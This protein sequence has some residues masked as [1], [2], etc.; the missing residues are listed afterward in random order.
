MSHYVSTYRFFLVCGVGSSR[1]VRI[2]H[3]L[4]R[5]DDGDTELI[6]QTLKGTQEPSQVILT[7]G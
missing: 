1:R 2:R 6:R 7:G 3:N 4:I 5:H